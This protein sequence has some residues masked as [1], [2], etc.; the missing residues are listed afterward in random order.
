[1]ATIREYISYRALAASWCLLGLA[2]IAAPPASAQLREAPDVRTALEDLAVDLAD[3]FS[4]A[5]EDLLLDQP[6]I[7]VSVMTDTDIGIVCQPLSSDARNRFYDLLSDLKRRRGLPVDF[8]QR[9][10]TAD[11][12]LFVRLSY[13]TRGGRIRF[14]ADV[15]RQTSDNVALENTFSASAPVADLTPEARVCVE[16][17]DRSFG[18]LSCTANRDLDLRDGIERR[19]GSRIAE[20]VPG[21]EF[22]VL[23]SYGNGMALLV[24]TEADSGFGAIDTVRGFLNA[25]IERLRARDA[26]TCSDPLMSTQVRRQPGERFAD[27]PDC[28]EVMVL[29]AG[30]YYAGSTPHEA[31]RTPDEPVLDRTTQPSRI[32]APFAIGIAEVSAREWAACAAEGVCRARPPQAPDVPVA[33]SFAEAQAYLGWLSEKTGARYRLPSE[34]EWVYAA[35]D[36]QQ[37]RYHW[38]ELLQPDVAVCRNCLSSG[39]PAAP[40]PAQSR[41]ANA[42][43]LHH[44]HGNLA[45]WVSDCWGGEGA[46]LAST[47]TNAC[48]FRTIK[49]GSFRDDA[50]L[51]R[52]ANRNYGAPEALEDTVGFRVVRTLE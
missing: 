33:V 51:L 26:I 37:S 25:D 45:E 49:G 3:Y 50:L 46:V 5:R 20:I 8:D 4:E 2:L 39:A 14:R 1:M 42:F 6:S 24:E 11:G 40:E 52:I 31:G 28:P 44:L 18:N 9:Q 32:E 10:R 15:A 27:C 23:A 43:G 41:P 34:G 29:P 36:R 19:Y 22:D 21:G 12:S 30:F 48:P 13:A 47:G 7:S 17:D 35:R 16:P 38:G